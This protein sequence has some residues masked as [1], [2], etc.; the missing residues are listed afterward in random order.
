MKVD[1]KEIT[2]MI[3]IADK[4]GTGVV[5]F[6][7]VGVR[8]LWFL[9]LVKSSMGKLSA[10]CATSFALLLLLPLQWYLPCLDFCCYHSRCSMV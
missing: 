4:E 9:D 3:K 5:K 2:E 8:D 10:C 1:Y 7:E 6:D